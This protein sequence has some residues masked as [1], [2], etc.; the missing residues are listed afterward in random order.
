MDNANILKILNIWLV[1]LKKKIVI[2]K[3]KILIFLIIG[4]GTALK[5][6]GVFQAKTMKFQLSFSMDLAPVENIGGII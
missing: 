5:F 2:L 1:I 4:I 3:K 6:V